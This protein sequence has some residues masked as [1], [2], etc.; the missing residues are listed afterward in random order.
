MTPVPEAVR[1]NVLTYSRSTVGIAF[2]NS[3]E[4]MGIR[5]FVFVACL[6]GS[7]LCDELITRL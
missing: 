2:S 7:S 6:G 4:D 5:F 3:T 1:S